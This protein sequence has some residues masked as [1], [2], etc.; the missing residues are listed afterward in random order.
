MAHTVTRG[1]ADPVARAMVNARRLA[2]MGMRDFASAVCA[3]LGRRSLHPSTV[4]KWE[5]GVVTP[6]ADVLVAAALVANVPIQVLFDDDPAGLGPADRLH[7]L[8]E[9]VRALSGR[10]ARLAGDAETPCS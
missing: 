3:K 4:S 2:G 10:V 5:H 6:P 7:R 1:A 9:Q 8:E